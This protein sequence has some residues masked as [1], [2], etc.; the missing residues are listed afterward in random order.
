MMRCNRS[1]LYSLSQSR[2]VSYRII[3]EWA[4]KGERL[5]RSNRKPLP[6]CV[7]GAIRQRFPSESGVY[8]GFQEA[9]DATTIL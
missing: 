8:A 3:M 7:V 2:L 9:E 4:L 6:S 1:F 5:G